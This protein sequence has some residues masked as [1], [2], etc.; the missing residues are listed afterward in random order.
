MNIIIDSETETICERK[1]AY[2]GDCVFELYIRQYFFSDKVGLKEM[3][4]SVI[5]VVNADFQFFLSKNIVFSDEENDYIR[6]IRNRKIP[7]PKGIKPSHYK[8]STA[9]EALIGK[10][11]IERS[12]DRL[13]QIMKNVFELIE[14]RLNIEK[15]D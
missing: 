12:K 14:E 8:Y 15:K 7:V 6:R 10:L 3:H 9:F 11:Y 2:I 13:E 4:D 5:S 1:L